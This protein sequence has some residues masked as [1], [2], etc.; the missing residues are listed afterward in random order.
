MRVVVR[1]GAS[2][3]NYAVVCIV[4]KVECVMHCQVGGVLAVIA[5]RV[6]ISSSLSDKAS[7]APKLVWGPSRATISVADYY[8]INTPLGKLRKLGKKTRVYIRF[9]KYISLLYV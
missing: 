1:V 6:E 3:G 5:L 2:G 7:H 8:R 4:R 9:G